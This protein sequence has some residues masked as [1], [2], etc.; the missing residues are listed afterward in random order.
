MKISQP[1]PQSTAA[2][3]SDSVSLKHVK[4]DD[5]AEVYTSVQKKVDLP[6]A[7]AQAKTANT[8]V[9]DE[10]DLSVPVKEGTKCTRKGC[11]K[12]FISEKESR[13]GEGENA[14]C[15]FH[16]S[17]VRQ[18][19]YL[20]SSSYTLKTATVPGREQSQFLRSIMSSCTKILAGIPLLQTAST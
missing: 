4:G 11:E 14:D 20:A 16:P 7:V 15:W 2:T 5:G 1:Q 3:Q 8:V 10:D 13:M 9:L 17:P 12:E 19:Y 6:T 18:D